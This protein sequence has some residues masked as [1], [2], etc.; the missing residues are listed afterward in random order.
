MGRG[1]D[2]NEVF[3]SD[4]IVPEELLPRE[5]APDAAAL[6]AENASLRDR[7]LRALA[8]AEN[9]RQRANRASTEARQY[10]VADFARELLPV[11][12]NLQRAIEAAE[13]QAPETSEEAALIEG[14]RATERM[15][16]A[17]L[18]R[19]G[20]RK[21]E[22]LGARFNPELHEAMMEIDD[23]AH[24]PGT[25]VRVVQD[26]YMIHDRLLRPARVVVAKRRSDA[27]N[28]S[29]TSAPEANLKR[30]SSD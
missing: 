23:P 24:R 18:E 28:P 27:A 26:G 19:F 30:H 7:L 4:S 10:A 2:R 17:T 15:L 3:M 6:E 13:R 9:T 20:V 16:M 21:I 8:E 11:V 25:V 14:V 12:D 29:R 1:E 22:A 5:E